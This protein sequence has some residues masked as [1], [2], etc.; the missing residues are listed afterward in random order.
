MFTANDIILGRRSNIRIGIGCDTSSGNVERSV[1]T[2]DNDNIK[3]YHRPEELVN[4]LYS[5]KIDAAIRGDMPSSELLQVLKVKAGVGG[6][7]RMAIL[8]TKMGRQIFLAPVGIDEGWTVEQKYDMTKRSV[9]MIRGLGMEPRIAIMSGGR[10]EDI[11]R[12]PSVDGSIKDALELVARLNKEGY[13][14][15]HA[16]ILIESAVEEAD[17]IVAPDGVAGNLIFR[18]L[19]FIAN[20][21]ASGAPVMNIDKVFVDTSRAKTDYIDSILLAMRLAEDRK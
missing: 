20:A 11:G 6:L 7:E 21:V 17:L 3:M 8:E 2:F 18:M 1:S 5:G 14:S 12:N 13:N 9:D 19:H 16:E 4:D 15:Y 10:S